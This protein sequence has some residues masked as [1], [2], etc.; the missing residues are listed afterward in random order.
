MHDHAYHPHD[1]A[2]APRSFG[3]AFGVG[4]GLNAAFIII[5]L[6]FG[7]LAGSTALLADAGHNLSDVLG[8]VIAWGASALARRPPTPRYT[9][10]LLGTTIMAAL[11]NAVFLLVAVGAIVWE[12]AHRLIEPTPV[13][14][15]TVMVVAGFG[16]LI[17][18]FTAWLF[19]AG[20][21]ADLNVRGAFLHMAA[22]AA[23]SAG[24]V[25]AGGAILFTG[26][27]WID[28]VV[29]LLIAA[30]IVWGTWGMLKESWRLSLN[31]VPEAIGLDEVRAFLAAQPGVTEVHD[32]HVWAMST[33]E[34]A[35]T[36][37]LVM[38]AGHAGDPF[39]LD[40]S[41][42]L[43]QRFGIGHT[44][45]QVETDPESQCHLA[46]DHVV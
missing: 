11:F 15:L 40:L 43:R 31:A 25:I 45:I 29:S 34:T 3:A 21:K 16:I 10:G 19:A 26:R 37:H 36:C 9:Y 38:P 44:T 6:V 30:V 13:A 22:D 27:L 23:V 12:A 20:R 4:I 33:T 2:H 8:L 14:G 5:E 42:A 28:P 39:L 46:P 32:L 17:N 1:H 24:V 7:L 18:G 41:R 35:L